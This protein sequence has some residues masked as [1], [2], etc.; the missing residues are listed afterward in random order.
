MA[1]VQCA[2]SQLA[3]RLSVT[4][5]Q[6]A[7]GVIRIANSNMTNALKLI[8]VNKGYDPRDFAFIAFGGGGAMHA[9]A[10][11]QEIGARKV[12]IPANAGVFSAWGMLMTDLRR[13]M[14]KTEIVTVKAKC[15]E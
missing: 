15:A 8:S 5:E 12:I 3:D 4:K 2:F 14:L 13:D 11:A 10:L 7:L 1:A 6:A 9:V